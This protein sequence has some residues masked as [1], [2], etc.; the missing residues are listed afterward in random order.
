[1]PFFSPIP[2]FFI[3]LFLIFKIFL[4]FFFLFRVIPAAYEALKLGVKSEAHLLAVQC[5]IR[6]ASVTYS[7]ALGNVGSLTH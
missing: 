1:M 2:L 6:A 5:R 7:T 4:H 3:Y